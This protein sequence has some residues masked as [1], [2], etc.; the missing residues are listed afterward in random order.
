MDTTDLA[1]AKAHARA[2]ADELESLGERPSVGYDPR[3]GMVAVSLARGRQCFDMGIPKA[4]ARYPV[5]WSSTLWV[6]RGEAS[7]ADVARALAARA[8]VSWSEERRGFLGW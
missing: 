6:V 4:G 2:I 5:L 7:P 8:D 1:E 3:L